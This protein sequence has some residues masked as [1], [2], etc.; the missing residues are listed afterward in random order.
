MVRPPY[1][2]AGVEACKGVLS[3]KD[4]NHGDISFARANTPTRISGV[5]QELGEHKGT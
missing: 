5:V 1:V 4:A 2:C 3:H